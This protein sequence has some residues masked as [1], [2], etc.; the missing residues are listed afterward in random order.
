VL[1]KT[2]RKFEEGAT[3]EPGDRRILDKDMGVLKKLAE[4]D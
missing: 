1:T 2:F 4:A 3:L